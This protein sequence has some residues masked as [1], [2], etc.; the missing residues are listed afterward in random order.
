MCRHGSVE[1]GPTSPS[2]TDMEWAVDGALLGVGTN[3]WSVY[4]MCVCLCVRLYVYVCVCMCVCVR[5]RVLTYARAS[6]PL[7]LEGRVTF[8]K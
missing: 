6:Q 8:S 4:G 5:A 1:M 2:G 7:V 3:I